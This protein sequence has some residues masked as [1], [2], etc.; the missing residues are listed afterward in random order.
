MKHIK[1]ETIQST[2]KI[3]IYGVKTY[4]LLI[5]EILK[6]YQNLQRK[7]IVLKYKDELLG[8]EYILMTFYYLAYQHFKVDGLNKKS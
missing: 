1:D 5:E 7:S 6:H 4:H 8:G 2:K 3:N